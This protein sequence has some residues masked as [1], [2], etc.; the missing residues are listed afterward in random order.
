MS[1]DS[2]IAALVEAVGPAAATP[3][4]QLAQALSAMVD[5]ARAAWPGVDVD[6]PAFVRYVAERLPQL[7]DV[8]DE[9]SSV[10]SDGLYLAC[11]CAS[12]DTKAIEQFEATFA[13]EVARALARLGIEATLRTEVVAELLAH[14][15]YGNA[16]GGASLISSFG[17]RGKLRSWVQS[18]A[19]HQA[20]K[21]RRKDRPLVS[22]DQIAFDIPDDRTDPE[23]AYLRSF[24]LEEFRSALGRAMTMLPKDSRNLLRQH[25]LD[26]MSLEAVARVHRVHRATAARWLADARDDVLRR[27]KEEL[28]QAIGL[29]PSEVDSVL[30]FV[31]RQSS[32]GV[33]MSELGRVMKR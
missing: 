19:V 30:A 6:A 8:L 14:L 32:F 22:V 20:L 11:A 27:T 10:D 12:R 31:Q 5:R 4:A 16:E 15:F 13:P 28:T 21:V 18:V 25:Y 2:L 1:A 23:M 33:H 17:G 26:R 3:D 24:Y 29:G 7:D 9:L